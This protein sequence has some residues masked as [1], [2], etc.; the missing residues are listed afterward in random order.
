M[1]LPLAQTN[2]ASG[3]S[4]SWG[5]ASQLLGSLASLMER[6]DQ[7]ERHFEDALAMNT[8]MGHQP[9]LLKTRVEYAAM[10]MRRARSGDRT[11]AAELARTAQAHAERLGLRR[12]AERAAGIVAAAAG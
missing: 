10:L 8:R 4:L 9:G 5:S 6:Y 2:W 1:I 3:S 11:R 12:Q 7:A